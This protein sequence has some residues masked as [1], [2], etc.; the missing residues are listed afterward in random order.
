[1]LRIIRSQRYS[2]YIC[3]V[4]SSLLLSVSLLYTRLSHSQS[5]YFSYCHQIPISQNDDI[6]FSNPLISDDSTTAAT[7]IPAD[8]SSIMSAGLRCSSPTWGS[9]SIITTH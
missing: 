4:I 9:S 1:M 5:H 2:V 3:T 6:S 7:T 8:F